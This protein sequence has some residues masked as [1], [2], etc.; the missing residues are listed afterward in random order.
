MMT[1]MTTMVMMMMTMLI[2]VIEV[3]ATLQDCFIAAARLSIDQ[4]LH[5]Q[6]LN[7]DDHED[8]DDDIW[9]GLGLGRGNPNDVGIF[10]INFRCAALTRFLC[11]FQTDQSDKYLSNHLFPFSGTTVSSDT[12]SETTMECFMAGWRTQF[13]FL[14]EISSLLEPP[15]NN[16]STLTRYGYYDQ[17][18]KLQIVNYH[19]DPHKGS[20]K[21]FP[22]SKILCC[23]K[24]TTMFSPQ[25]FLC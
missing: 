12:K 1:M 18:G 15:I 6:N 19:A 24:P 3:S 2:G 22:L 8:L 5:R 21:L 10:W 11:F 17:A 23:V 25:R 9:D 20:Q 16:E 4:M 7:D 14:G 13:L